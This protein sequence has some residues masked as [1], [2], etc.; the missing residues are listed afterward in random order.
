MKLIDLTGHT[1]GRLT[2]TGRA[3]QRMYGKHVAWN[4]QCDC[5]GTVITIG[6]SLRRGAVNSCGCIRRNNH[7]HITYEA[8][9]IR[10]KQAKGPAAEW[11]CID[12]GEPAA[13]WS[14][15]HADNVEYVCSKR[16]VLYS[17][18]PQRYQPRCRTCHK[19][20]DMNR[21]GVADSKPQTQTNPHTKLGITS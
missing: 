14:Y 16:Y 5:G 6:G 3:D 9:H 7:S 19:R 2:V 17:I 20:H 1:F 4:C 10:V 21:R 15:D 12:C 18:D 11:P 8:A 13:E